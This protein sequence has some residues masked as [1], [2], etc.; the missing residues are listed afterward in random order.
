M[1]TDDVT[2]NL[3]RGLDNHSGVEKV[4][5]IINNGEETEFDST[6]KITLDRSGIYTID[7][8]TYNRAGNS[9]KTD[10]TLEIKL[11]KEAPRNVTVDISNLRTES[12]TITANAEDEISGLEG[13]KYF[14]RVKEAEEYIALNEEFTTESLTIRGLL[15]DET[16]EIYAIAKDKAGNIST[17]ENTTVKEVSTLKLQPEELVIKTGDNFAQDYEEGTWTNKDVKLTFAN[18]EGST[19]ESIEES[20]INIA[21]TNEETV[22]NQSGVV[23]VK[24]T[25]TDGTNTV[26]SEAYVIKVDKELPTVEDIEISNTEWTNENVIITVKG[27]KDAESG[28]DEKPYSFDGGDSWQADNSKE[29]TENAKDVVVCV[30]DIAGN[31]YRNEKISIENIDNTA[32]TTTKPVVSLTRTSI[33]VESKQEDTGIG[34]AKVMYGIRRESQEEITWQEEPTFTGL[35][36]GTYYV[37][38]KATDKLGNTS[39]SE[40]TK[41][42]MAEIVFAS[43]IYDINNDTMQIINIAPDTSLKSFKNNI[44]ANVEYD[45]INKEGKKLTETDLVGTG[46]KVVI[47]ALNNKT[48]VNIVRGDLNGDGQVTIGDLARI[49]KNIIGL[50]EL[51]ELQT[52]AADLNG[53]GQVAI[54]D[55]SKVVKAIIGLIKI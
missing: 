3:T 14:I 7:V 52:K 47:P 2:I 22:I 35:P 1:V 42:E 51:D 8:I 23:Y 27:A 18:Q 11:D 34:I 13:Y 9:T 29:Y 4:T 41:A 17:I 26:Q 53:D 40:E 24:V 15:T 45:V 48:Y 10:T 54:S 44:I 31:I 25:T 46:M 28:L 19:Y 55:L 50:N 37:R 39:E 33:T 38:T 6:N 16:Y 30:K 49:K 32:P 21:S 20:T 5:Y 12:M 43:E 36:E